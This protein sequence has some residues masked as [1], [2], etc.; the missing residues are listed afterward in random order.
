MVYVSRRPSR[1]RREQL[2][3]L[4][5]QCLRNN[6]ENHVSGVLLVGEDWF[7]QMLEGPA[8]V[9]DALFERIEAD[10]RHWDVRLLNRRTI[11][12]P[13][14]RAWGMLQIEDE[15]R[16]DCL[17]ASVGAPTPFD[18]WR[19]APQKLPLVLLAAAQMALDEAAFASVD[20]VSLVVPGCCD[21]SR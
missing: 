14:S 21:L 1:S 20:C 2:T 17:A 8:P 3:R 16:L 19:T 13:L 12:Q 10:P 15:K 9:L 18:P 6:R 5:Q 4:K 7:L 11:E